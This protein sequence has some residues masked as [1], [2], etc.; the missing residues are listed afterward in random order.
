MSLRMCLAYLKNWGKRHKE[1]VASD[2][3]LFD[4]D[5]VGWCIGKSHSVRTSYKSEA[6]MKVW[7]SKLDLKFDE[8]VIN[9]SHLFE[10]DKEN[11]VRRWKTN[12]S[13]DWFM[14][15][16]VVE[17]GEA[18]D[19]RTGMPW[20]D[21]VAR[22]QI[23]RF[24]FQ[25]RVLTS[26]KSTPTSVY[27][28]S[29]DQL[30]YAV[31]VAKIVCESKGARQQVVRV[32]RTI[33]SW[34]KPEYGPL[35]EGQSRRLY[36]HSYSWGQLKSEVKR[37]LTK[38]WIHL[39]LSAAHFSIMR[40]LVERELEECF[41]Q[42]VVSDLELISDSGSMVSSVPVGSSDTDLVDL[43][44]EG[45]GGGM[46][47]FNL[48][49]PLQSNNNGTHTPYRE[50]PLKLVRNYVVYGMGSAKLK[51][52]L[53]SSDV[54]LSPTEADT[55]INDP[56]VEALFRIRAWLFARIKARGFMLDA[57]GHRV[58][59][60][61]MPEKKPAQ[62][63]SVVCETYEFELLNPV[64]RAVERHDGWITLYEHDGLSLAH[65]GSQEQLQAMR[66]DCIEVV[67][68]NAK[69]LGIPTRFV[70]KYKNERFEPTSV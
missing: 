39:D 6:V 47:F 17:E 58:K 37:A 30:L 18:I 66:D 46:L 4:H 29:I 27:E 16:S 38:D 55:V 21:D 12:W 15:E 68:A 70:E 67:N 11:K 69:R 8:V 19:V 10:G 3:I 49:N 34:P 42:D 53:M 31:D 5:V 59:L 48:S 40:F 44:S 7:L 25:N 9:H 63:L 32:L 54:G 45:G 64:I 28:R 24:A 36:D 35:Q 65:E 20:V 41:S 56:Q 62:V 13:P 14:E 33:R 26:L 23:P 43:L 50:A 57:F 52:H 60:S 61:A 1:E 51:L 22:K 2:L